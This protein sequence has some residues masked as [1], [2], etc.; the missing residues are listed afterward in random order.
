MLDACLPASL[1]RWGPLRQ[2]ASSAAPHPGP[3][4]YATPEVAVDHAYHRPA[5]RRPERPDQPYPRARFGQGAFLG[6]RCGRRQRQGRVPAP[7]R[8]EA[9]PGPLGRRE[10]DHRCW[11]DRL[12]VPDPR[13]QGGEGVVLR[14]RG[15]AGRAAQPADRAQRAV[16]HQC[17]PRDCGCTAGICRG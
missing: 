8:R 15:R 17:V 10:H 3:P 16:C 5:A 11:K 13:G 1:S 2:P 6:R 7:V 12:A 4:T 14:Y 9:R